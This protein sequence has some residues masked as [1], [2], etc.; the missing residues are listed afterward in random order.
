MKKTIKFQRKAEKED[1]KKLEKALK[2]LEK[3]E[4]AYIDEENYVITVTLLDSVDD[5]VFER[6]LEEADYEVIFID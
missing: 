6:L 1:L 2:K 3:V 4:D 5:C